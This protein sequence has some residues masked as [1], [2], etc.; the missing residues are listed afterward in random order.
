MTVKVA[1]V[2]LGVHLLPRR[3][4]GS[5]GGAEPPSGSRGKVV[6]VFCPLTL[7][8]PSVLTVRVHEFEGVRMRGSR[9]EGS[10][11]ARGECEPSEAT[12]DLGIVSLL[13]RRDTCE[14]G[15]V[16]GSGEAASGRTS[17][18]DED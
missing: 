14:G 7:G 8:R 13:G 15:L 11:N 17:S 16:K 4:V 18:G 3:E 2:E 1:Q 9:R 5:G 10:N 6:V 12:L